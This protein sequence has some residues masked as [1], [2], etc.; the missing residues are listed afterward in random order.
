VCEWPFASVVTVV[1]IEC[2]FVPTFVVDTVE[3]PLSVSCVIDVVVLVPSARYRTVVVLVPCWSSEVVTS[4]VEPSW[5][6]VV[7]VLD[8]S[9]A[10]SCVSVVSVVP[11][12]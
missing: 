1:V 11:R 5:C 2:P 4:F 12:P 7:V 6:V 9:V 10:V 3:V 8:L